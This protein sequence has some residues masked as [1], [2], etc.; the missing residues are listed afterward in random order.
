MKIVGMDV[1]EAGRRRV[2]VASLLERAHDQF[3]LFLLNVEMIIEPP[4]LSRRPRFEDGT[5]ALTNT[6]W[7]I[8]NGDLVTNTKCQRLLDHVLQ[9]A[10]VA[11]PVMIVKALQRFRSQTKDRTTAP[12]GMFPHEIGG[13]QWN[14]C[15]AFSKSGRASVTTLSR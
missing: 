5:Q 6:R 3:A 8:F 11:G 13:Q 12:D 9:L 4:W 7:K 2:A 1:E 15:L 10:D 14:V